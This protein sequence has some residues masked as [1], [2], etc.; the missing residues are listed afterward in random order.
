MSHIEYLI[1]NWN[2]PL[3]FNCNRNIPI[4]LHF[5]AVPLSEGISISFHDGLNINHVKQA[6]QQSKN[7]CPA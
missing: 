4:A 3:K 7:P 2:P 5:Y 6:K 1:V